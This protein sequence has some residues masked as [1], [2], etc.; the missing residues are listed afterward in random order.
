MTI[1]LYDRWGGIKP[2]VYRCVAENY[3]H[4]VIM[5]RGKQYC[6]PANLFEPDKRVVKYYDDEE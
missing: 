2:G 5:W 6:V 1:K 4:K 3:D